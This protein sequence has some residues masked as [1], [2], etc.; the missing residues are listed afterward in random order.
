MQELAPRR[1]RAPQRHRG[2][3]PLRRLVEAPDQRRQHV[4]V[5]GVEVVARAIKVRRHDRAVVA[6]VLPVVALAQLDARDLGDGVGLVGGLE[7]ARQQRVLGHRLGGELGVDAGRAEEQEP[8]HPRQVGGV[9]HVRLDHQVLVEELGGIGVVGVDAPHLRRGQDH[10]VGLRLGEEGAHR[11]LVGQVQLRAAAG[12]DLRLGEPHRAQA[13]MD[14][15]AH[16]AAMA[17]EE[18]AGLGQGAHGS[19]L[20][21]WG[22]SV[23]TAACSS[24]TASGRATNSATGIMAQP[25]P[26]S[27]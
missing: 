11:A 23:A 22:S 1:A 16:H 7:R 19:D 21:G 8:L 13:A 6:P 25:C 17:G 2:V 26:S 3:A 15:R 27:P 24:A 5:L 20:P 18:D 12:E 9:D 14:R 4:G 10:H